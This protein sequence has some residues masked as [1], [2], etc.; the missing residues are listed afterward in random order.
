MQAT[1]RCSL[2]DSQCKAKSSNSRCD[3]TSSSHVLTQ[4]CCCRVGTLD[5]MSPEV[6]SLPTADERKKMEAAG[7]PAMEQPYGEK[8]KLQFMLGLCLE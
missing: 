1:G 2:V 7:R 3:N 4:L 6:V 8:V 5:Y